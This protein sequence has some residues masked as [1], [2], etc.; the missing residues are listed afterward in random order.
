MGFPSGIVRFPYTL[1]AGQ[2][3]FCAVLLTLIRAGERQ[4][5]K[6]RRYANHRQPR[7]LPAPDSKR[8]SVVGPN[9][10]R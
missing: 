9:C 7:E 2:N 10:R 4:S 5:V 1:L 6:W 8:I 3:R